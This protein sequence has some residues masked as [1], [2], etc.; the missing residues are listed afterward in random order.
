MGVRGAE[1]AIKKS[2]PKQ[3]YVEL[4]GVPIAYTK[5]CLNASNWITG[6]LNVSRGGRNR[7]MLSGEVS[8]VGSITSISRGL[9]RAMRFPVLMKR[10]TQRVYK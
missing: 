3:Y 9:H 2:L 1:D 8:M 5:G 10:F 6:P 4:D 7:S